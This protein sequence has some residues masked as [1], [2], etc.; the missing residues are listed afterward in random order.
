[1]FADGDDRLDAVQRCSR[2]SVIIIEKIYVP[3]VTSKRPWLGFLFI[4]EGSYVFSECCGDVVRSHY[5]QKV[6]RLI[7]LLLIMGPQILRIDS[8]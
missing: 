2:E 1:M 8:N 3:L 6:L 4:I 7:C 5:T